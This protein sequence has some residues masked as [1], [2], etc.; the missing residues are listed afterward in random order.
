MF[1]EK[2]FFLE[3]LFIKIIIEFVIEN[4]EKPMCWDVE[5]GICTTITYGILSC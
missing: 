2:L 3:I 4:S 1:F 5:E